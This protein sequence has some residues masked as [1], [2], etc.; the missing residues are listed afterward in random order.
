[1]NYDTMDFIQ[2]HAHEIREQT[3]VPRIPSPKLLDEQ[4]FPALINK[5]ESVRLMVTF[6]ASDPYKDFVEKDKTTEFKVM[7]DKT[8][9]EL[10]KY[11]KN[12]SAQMEITE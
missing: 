9:K 1:M 3:H 2:E 6:Y 4:G 11:C 10:V 7:D 8:Y 12:L 5:D